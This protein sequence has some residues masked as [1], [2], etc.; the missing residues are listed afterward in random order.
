MAKELL[1]HIDIDYLEK[2]GCIL[3]ARSLRYKKARQFLGWTEKFCAPRFYT[4]GTLTL[5]VK[6]LV[7]EHGLRPPLIGSFDLN[8][9]VT[10]QAKI[11]HK[12][13]RRAVKNSWDR[14]ERSS[15][16]AIMVLNPDEVETQVLEDRL[17]LNV[18]RCVHSTNDRPSRF[19]SRTA[20]KALLDRWRLCAGAWT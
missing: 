6:L 13:I 16:A 8:S 20:G 17:V 7:S 4:L 19:C 11:L 2:S 18:I 15:R 12:L 14:R 9:W 3:P 1:D 5:A 10:D